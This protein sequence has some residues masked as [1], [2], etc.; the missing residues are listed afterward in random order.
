MD[1][2]RD[3]EAGPWCKAVA[4]TLLPILHLVGARQISLMSLLFHA[5]HPSIFVGFHGNESTIV[6]LISEELLEICGP[7]LDPQSI[8]FT[9]MG[10]ESRHASTIVLPLRFHD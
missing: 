5:Q 9:P 6:S 10:M 3:F 8:V 7:F 4:W 2:L 1:A